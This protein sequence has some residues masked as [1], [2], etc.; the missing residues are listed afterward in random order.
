MGE[1]D[2]RWE[3]KK[4]ETEAKRFF[5]L[6]ISITLTVFMI[7]GFFSITFAKRRL[8]RPGV[9]IEMRKLFHRKHMLYVNVLI[10]L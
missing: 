10:M 2:C 3:G 9:S 7:V 5:N 1:E 4:G 8:V 6:G